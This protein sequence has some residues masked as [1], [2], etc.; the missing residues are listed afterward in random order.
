MIL[1]YAIQYSTRIK[2]VLLV[3]LLVSIAMFQVAAWTAFAYPVLFY[4]QM[5]IN[6]IIAAGLV[7][8]S[9]ARLIKREIEIDPNADTIVVNGTSVSAEQVQE[10]RISGCGKATFELSLRGKQVTP[11]HCRFKFK[12]KDSEGVGELS[13]WAEMHRIPLKKIGPQTRTAPS[14]MP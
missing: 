4:I 11:M 13:R 6:V 12:D 9:Y 5:G 14:T 3:S 10:I 7:I 2:D 1:K 8:E